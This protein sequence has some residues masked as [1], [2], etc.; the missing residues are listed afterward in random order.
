MTKER[1]VEFLKKFVFKK[2][3]N[4]LLILDN[5]G[6]HRNEYVKKD[7]LESGNKYLFSIP[8]TPKT[9]V[10]EMFFR[11]I[12]HYLKLNDA[13]AFKVLRFDELNKEVKQAIRKASKDNYK[14]YFLYA[15]KKNKIN[16]AKRKVSILRIKN[17]KK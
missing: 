8:Y 5:A 12:K 11:Q 6:S 1:F 9:N 2:Y 13:K 14:N 3:K 15:Y 17:I 16:K 4:H 10:I 7:I